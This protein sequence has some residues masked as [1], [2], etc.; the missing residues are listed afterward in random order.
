MNN[1]TTATKPSLIYIEKVENL[2]IGNIELATANIYIEKVENLHIG[3]TEPVTSGA[4]HYKQPTG[5]HE[6]STKPPLTNSQ[7]V[8]GCYYILLSLGLRPRDTL[9]IADAARFMHFVTAKTY[10]NL[11]ITLALKSCYFTKLHRWFLFL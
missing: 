7:L 8:L 9:S 1:N 11:N 10:T 2:H 4:S 5:P 6:P 3:K